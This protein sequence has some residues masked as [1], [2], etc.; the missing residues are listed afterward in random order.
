MNWTAAHKAYNEACEYNTSHW[1]GVKLR[2]WLKS[3]SVTNKA[4]SSSS[5]Y[6]KPTALA[7]GCI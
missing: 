1:H 3:R 5:G 4:T 7:I 6:L 2:E